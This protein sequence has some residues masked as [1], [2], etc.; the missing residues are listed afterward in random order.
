LRFTCGGMRC[1]IPLGV[2]A[3]SQIAFADGNWDRV[4]DELD[5]AYKKGLAEVEEKG[6]SYEL[7]TYGDSER[8]YDAWKYTLKAYRM[9]SDRLAKERGDEGVQYRRSVE[10]WLAGSLEKLEADFRKE[11]DGGSYAGIFHVGNKIAL[12]E[13]AIRLLM[14]K[15]EA[16]KRWARISSVTWETSGTTVSFTNGAACVKLSWH[17]FE[18]KPNDK[19]FAWAPYYCPEDTYSW[20]GK[21]YAVVRFPAE[22]NLEGCPTTTEE[23]M[24]FEFDHSAV[25]RV[26]GLHNYLNKKSELDARNGRLILF[27]ED[28]YSNPVRFVIDLKTMKILGEGTKLSSEYV[29][30]GYDRLFVDGGAR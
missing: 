26:I 9:V 13:R 7:T 27:G 14:L 3:L 4:C 19:S 5:A 17:I 24:V 8:T 16:A 30:D 25:N 15:T 6:K 12:Y 2:I 28:G 22:G 10:K 29:K 21:D 20:N 18:A 23:R 11:K 1:V